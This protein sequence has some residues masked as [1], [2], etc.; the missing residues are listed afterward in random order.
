MVKIISL[1]CAFLLLSINP[2][3]AISSINVDVIREA[4]SY[5]KVKAHDQLKDFLL[6]WISYEEQSVK[7]DETAEHAYLYTA[8][9]LMATDSREKSLN[10]QSVT[11]LDSE[12]ILADYTDLLS[13][14]V[15][16]F[17][18][19]QDFT[20]NASV[21]LKQDKKIIKAYQA[22]IPTHGEQISKEEGRPVYKGQCYL[23]FIEKD[24][25]LTSPI[26]L[27][28]TTQDK[29]EHTFYFD[30]EKIK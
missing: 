19:K 17:G 25:D 21:I 13:F 14:S 28:V 10:G 12:R 22:N 16:L 26:R 18:D 4:Q 8:F 23:Y 20:Q 2:V 3:L 27:V 1:L 30:M 5:G 15:A 7:L 29:K 11:L 9:L 6:P 24:I